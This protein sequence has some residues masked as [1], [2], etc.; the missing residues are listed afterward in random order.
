MSPEQARGQVVD[1]R[2]D[3]WSFGLLLFEMLTGKGMFSGKSF[4]ET[5][6]AVIHR[7][8]PEDTPLNIRELVERCLRKDPRMRLRDMGDAPY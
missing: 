1:K 8:L 6:A 3:I 4:T 7:E 5:P 2:T